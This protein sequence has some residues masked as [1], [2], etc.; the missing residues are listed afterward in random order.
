MKFLEEYEQVKS[1]SKGIISGPITRTFDLS[2]LEEI[3]KVISY[4]S[5]HQP[6]LKIIIA[7]LE[8][9]V[10]YDICSAL[11]FDST[12]ANIILRPLNTQVLR[13]KDTIKTMLIESVG[14][15]IGEDIRGK[16]FKE[17][18][19]P[20]NENSGESIREN[21]DQLGSF[22]NI[23]F[24]AYGRIVGMINVASCRSDAFSEGDVKGIYAIINQTSN[25]IG[26]LQEAITAEKSR[27]ESMVK[28]IPEGVIM[29][30]QK[31]EIVV[32]NP[33]A[34][35]MLSFGS[36][37]LVTSKA[38]NEKLKL[39]GLNKMFKESQR[40][41]HSIVREINIV[42]KNKSVVLRSSIS[43]VKDTEG[44]I[45]GI[46]AILRDI[47]REKEMD[48][49]KTEFISIVSHELRTPLTTMK[50]F[51][52]II[53][54]EIPGK[55]TEGQREYVNIIQ[56]NIDRLARLIGN[57][58]NISKIESGS[59]ELKKELIDVVKIIE[60][61]VLTLRPGIDEK[62]INLK[63]SPYCSQVFV[64]AD[65]D[66]IFQIF[67][68][69][70]NNAIK[71]T[72]DNG[73]ITVKMIDKQKEVEFIVKDTG[74]GIASENIDKV[75]DRFQ[76]FGRTTGS[77]E[78]GTGLGLAITKE[79]IKEHHGK[80]WVKSDLEKGTKFC[81]FLPKYDSKSL[82]KSLLK[83]CISAGADKVS[84]QSL[85]ISL[86]RM[87]LID[88]EKLRQELANDFLDAALRGMEDV[89]RDS[90]RSCEV[91]DT[92]I[93]VPMGVVV[94]LADC[95]K[96]GVSKARDRLKNILDGYLIRRKLSDKIEFQLDC[97]TYPDDV[98]TAEE[99]ITKVN[100]V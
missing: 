34:R 67:T 76:Q 94:V 56:G 83:E 62:K 64:Y 100:I 51:T 17:V 39:F 1:F 75:F 28:S 20:F 9:I 26:R 29:L 15:L 81:F 65:P 31:D 47:T 80:I 24:S 40:E 4:T 44:K 60:S 16:N 89:L 85:K 49:M 87:S 21:C 32:L 53:A 35:M 19:I 6:L 52:S 33:Q 46:V 10:K 5:G 90:L 27:M 79:L 14:L 7:E 18:L 48:R 45:I 82:L 66:S 55:L 72:P 22:F 92:V 78:K 41:M 63:I 36:N 54:D 30:D 97:L 25:A 43:P 68:N 42:Q 69:L 57:L 38:L 61:V 2:V 96:Q 12:T 71:F 98:Q 84:G 88:A 8:K 86:I 93:N 74:I 37:T 23:P 77:G 91:G 99:M 3:A 13:H 11:F 70:V 73:E 95:D 59:T 58:L 50:E